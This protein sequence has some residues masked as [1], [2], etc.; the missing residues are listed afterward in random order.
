MNIYDHLLESDKINGAT[1]RSLSSN[2][3]P[4]YKTVPFIKEEFF[5]RIY[6]SKPTIT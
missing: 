3:R 1:K 2:G 4:A 6:W 5:N